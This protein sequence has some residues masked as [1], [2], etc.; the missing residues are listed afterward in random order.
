MAQY[1]LGMKKAHFIKIRVTD[2]EKAA[3]DAASAA[4]GKTMSEAI[5][6]Y[7]ARVVNKNAKAESS[8][9]TQAGAQ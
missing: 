2:G 1:A 4:R 9:E 8:R 3:F 7:M 5:R 6:E